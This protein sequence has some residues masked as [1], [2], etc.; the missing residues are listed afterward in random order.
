MAAEALPGRAAAPAAAAQRAAEPPTEGSIIGRFVAIITPILAV[1]ASAIAGWVAHI[2][3]GVK[4]DK[5][6]IVAFMIAVVTAALTAG[7]KYLDGMQKHEQRVSEGTAA[8]IRLA[9]APLPP[10]S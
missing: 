4:L 9:K 5:G 6:E 1:A 2:F 7:W 3:P 8:P 10:R